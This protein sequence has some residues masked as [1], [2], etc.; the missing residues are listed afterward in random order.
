MDETR[1][2]REG[3]SSGSCQ[4]CS[5]TYIKGGTYLKSNT[6]TGLPTSYPRLIDTF[7]FGRPEPSTQTA[8]QLGDGA[9][10][11]AWT[12]E[13][14]PGLLRPTDTLPPFSPTRGFMAALTSSA[15]F[16]PCLVLVRC[17]DQRGSPHPTVSDCRQ[18]L[19][20]ART[21]GPPDQT[22]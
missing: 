7:F 5:T 17:L 20:H 21:P 2:F 6:Q 18:D 16:R 8:I 12:G 22:D 13:G 15:P 19:S 11:G 14:L 10:P 4:Q 9:L 1:Q 3:P